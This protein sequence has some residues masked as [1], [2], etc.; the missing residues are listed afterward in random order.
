MNEISKEVIEIDGKEYTLF[1][2]RIGLVAIE[3]FTR[4]EMQKVEEAQKLVGSFESKEIVEINDDTDPFEGLENAEK[5]I[6]DIEKVKNKIYQKM[7]WVMLRTSHKLTPQECFDLY[8]KAV[9]EYGDQVNKLID[10]IV[11]DINKDK[12]TPEEKQKEVKNLK[13]LRPT[14]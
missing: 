3:K 13:A 2:N 12:A 7:F 8:D 5:A 4:E 9:E 1:L 11:E 10:Q 6:D 14:K